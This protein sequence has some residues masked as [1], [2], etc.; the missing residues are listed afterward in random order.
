[1]NP[2]AAA[3]NS[4][5]HPP[6]EESMK[7]L[8]TP[9]A[10]ILLAAPAFAQEATDTEKR[11]ADLEKK[12]AKLAKAESAKAEVKKDDGVSVK[13]GGRF[14]LDTVAYD[15][16]KYSLANGTQVRRARI[17]FKA[18]FGKDWIAEGDY[19]FAED[20]P[21]V[22]DMFLG[23]QGF[24]KT[25]IQIGQFKAPFGFD[26]LSSSNGTWFTERSYS[27]A[28]NP[29][30]HLGV[31]YQTWGERWQA[32]VNF[33][34]Q[35]I[36]DTN[37]H[38]GADDTTLATDHGW[39]Y[40]G[41]VTFAPVL[42]SD[43]KA[44]HFGVATAYRKP[45]AGPDADANTLDLSA[46]PEAGKISKSKFLNAKVT[47]VDN[48]TQL[49]GEFVGVWGPFSWQSEYQQLKVQRRAGVGTTAA[50]ILASSQDHTFSTYY[51]QVSWIFG[52]QRSYEAADGLFGKVA[53]STRG[54]W[55]VVARYSSMK[56]DDITAIDPIK[57]G[58]AKNLSMGVTYYQNKNIRWMLDYV[59]VDN[60]EFAVPNKR[61]NGGVTP[62]L[63]ADKFAHTTFR[64][65]VN[66]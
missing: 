48:W 38:L 58:T 14:H 12:I 27:D 1:M 52:G 30:R 2:G 61:Y 51:G 55:E 54:A 53:P 37:D 35:A 46:R 50:A 4:P 57:K 9:L 40:A 13:F 43:T 33:F 64:L 8:I 15:G 22:K 5:F 45:N 24:K 31:A 47:N 28:W 6:P 16:S 18:T 32:K 65:Q 42:V 17:S 23:Y 63:V 49:G 36:D 19:D 7:S 41:R 3:P 62:T 29:D 11:I 25:L 56:Q 39:G 21:S 26:T 60:N 44:I 20:S 59:K 66:F 34:G 10:L